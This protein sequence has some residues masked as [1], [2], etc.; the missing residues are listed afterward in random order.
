MRFE[1]I[2]KKFWIEIY[3]IESIECDL[4]DLG[5]EGWEICGFTFLND[6]YIYTLKRIMK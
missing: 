4:N 1:Y 6:I 3:E 2:I 5:K